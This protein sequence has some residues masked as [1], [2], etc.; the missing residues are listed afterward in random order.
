MKK[1]YD[2][3]AIYNNE[4]S[5]LMKQ[6]IEICKEHDMTFFTCFAYKTEH[7]SASLNYSP[8]H[9]SRI[10]LVLDEAFKS[11]VTMNKGDKK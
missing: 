4:V 2:F 1:E 10:I 9:P 8:E 11:E 6:I 7:V 3:E 5:P